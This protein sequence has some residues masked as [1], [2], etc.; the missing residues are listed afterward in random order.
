MPTAYPGYTPPGYIVVRLLDVLTYRGH[1]CLVTELFDGTLSDQELGEDAG[2]PENGEA[3]APALAMAMAL[4][5]HA[6]SVAGPA[7]GSALGLYDQGTRDDRDRGGLQRL[8]APA[9]PGGGRLGVPAG[10][11]GGDGV[12]GGGG[13]GLGFG[14]PGTTS[15]ESRSGR[16][17]TSAGS[18]SPLSPSPSSS[19]SSVSGDVCPAHVIRH[20][21]LQLVSALL[22]LR[23]HG[24][25]HADI[26]PE[27]VLLRIEGEGWRGGGEG[28]AAAGRGQQKSPA[29]RRVGL[30]DLVR[31]RARM[32]GIESLTV[33]LCDFGNAIH[34]SE[35]Y[36]YYGDFEIQT[37][38][39]RA[40]EASY[41]LRGN[42]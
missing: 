25:I 27:N 3:A 42:A 11:G 39:Y 29:R 21:A 2:R 8:G 18:S 40:P 33:R 9:E 20:V 5:S 26:K 32:E 19:S 28:G 17:R 6:R 12:G 34:K 23:N 36:L 38:A 13:G 1:Y 4:D 24:L 16:R 22:L 31:G 35:A 41:I 30:R 14:R 7:R 10:W 15:G 37:L